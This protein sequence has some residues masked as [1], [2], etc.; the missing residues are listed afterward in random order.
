MQAGW[1]GEGGFF[2]DKRVAAKVLERLGPIKQEKESLFPL[3]KIMGDKYRC[4]RL[5]LTPSAQ[6]LNVQN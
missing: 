4:Q 6:Q 1:N 2:F 5:Q 3:K